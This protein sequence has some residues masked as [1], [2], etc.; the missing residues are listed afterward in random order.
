MIGR[1]YF[2]YCMNRPDISIYTLDSN[3]V[4][5]LG[6]LL[7]VDDVLSIYPFS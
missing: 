6:K 1:F 2:N 3:V 7:F 5:P 4:H